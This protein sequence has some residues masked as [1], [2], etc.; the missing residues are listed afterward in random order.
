[1]FLIENN[2]HPND[3]PQLP[4]VTRAF[5]VIDKASTLTANFSIILFTLPN[6][7]CSAAET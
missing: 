1:M 6:L 4:Q 7:E 5:D 3:L 2:Y